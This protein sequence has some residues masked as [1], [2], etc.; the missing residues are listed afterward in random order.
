MRCLHR[1]HRRPTHPQLRHAHHQPPARK[2]PPSKA[3]ARSHPRGRGERGI[4]LNSL[5]DHT[6]STLA[7]SNF[8]DSL[9]SDSAKWRS[10]SLRITEVA[11][12]A[13]PLETQMVANPSIVLLLNKC[14]PV[15]HFSD[16]RPRRINYTR[17]TGSLTPAGQTR[18]IRYD[19]KA[20]E[21]CSFLRLILPQH[22]VDF[23]AEEARRPGTRSRSS[24]IDVPFMDDP[25]RRSSGL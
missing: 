14:F 1:P 20:Q 9:A 4:Q 8:R 24:I 3:F 23:V 7:V 21:T 16:G 18:L 13:D 6:N 19:F 17:G 10:L 25:V 15:D 2:S 5:A 22:T 12:Y 11:R